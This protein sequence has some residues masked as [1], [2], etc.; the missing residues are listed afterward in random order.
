MATITADAPAPFDQTT[1]ANGYAY[2]EYLV[3]NLFKDNPPPQIAI[4][5]TTY[6][7]GLTER[8]PKKIQDAP[9]VEEVITRLGGANNS[10]VSL[11]CEKLAHLLQR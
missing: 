6:L 3:G 5:F 2:W 11:V 10:Y 9:R 1:T 8:N 4:E 7:D